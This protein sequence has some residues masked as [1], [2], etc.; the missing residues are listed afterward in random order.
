LS[1]PSAAVHRPRTGKSARD[2]T[3]LPEDTLSGL[4]DVFQMLADKSRLKIL[5]ALARDGEMHV[6]ALRQLL[7]QSQP[8]ISH[9]LGLL[10]S[11]KLVSYR[12]DGKKNYYS[13]DSS[14]VRELLDEFFGVA[15]N[16]QRQL[17]LDGCCVAFKS[18]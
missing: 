17:Y 7:R 8:A 3:P 15:G 2:K 12:R 10:R 11:H 5:L 14:L 9:H 1:T 18:G 13:I 4:V 16:G 6:A